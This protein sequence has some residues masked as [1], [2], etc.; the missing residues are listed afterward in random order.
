[1]TFVSGRF[2]V[3]GSPSCGSDALITVSERFDTRELVWVGEQRCEQCGAAMLYTRRAETETERQMVKKK[4]RARKPAATNGHAKPR[5]R[6][7]DLPG[8]ED[9]AIKPLED[10]AASYADVRDRR[11]ELNKEEADLKATALKLMKKYDKTIYRHDGIEIRIVPGEDDV[12][13]RVKPEGQ[14]EDEQESADETGTESEN[15]L[16]VGDDDEGQ[17]A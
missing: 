1:M 6:N 17:R 3:C 11:I 7:Q 12:K 9:R 2:T 16:E 5:P 8:M 10:V 15:R 13:V 4:T 14:D